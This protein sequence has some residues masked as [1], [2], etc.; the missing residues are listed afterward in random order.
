MIKNHSLDWMLKHSFIKIPQKTK[1][2][3]QKRMTNHL[4]D[5]VR[6][7]SILSSTKKDRFTLKRKVI[8]IKN[9]MGCLL[10]QTCSFIEGRLT[11]SI[12]LCIHLQAHLSQRQIRRMTCGRSRQ[13]YLLP[14]RGCYFSRH[15]MSKKTGFRCSN[16]S[17]ETKTSVNSTKQAKQLVMVPSARF[18]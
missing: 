12:M 14:N 8:S 9:S 4:K 2:K 7:K 6:F 18:I 5:L 17:Q 3:T 13:P 1:M 10:G 15:R 16:Q 11:P